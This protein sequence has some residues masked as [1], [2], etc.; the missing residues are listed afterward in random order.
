L[1]IVTPLRDAT[2]KLTGYSKILRDMTERKR[3]EDQLRLTEERFRRALSIGTVG[4][5]SFTLDGRLTDANGTF[6]RMSG[7][8]A[9]ELRALP[10][11]AVLTALPFTAVTDRVVDELAER[12]ETAPYEKQLLR[13]DGSSWWGLCAPTRL[14][15]SGRTAECLEFVIDITQAKAAAVA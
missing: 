4:V 3:A 14:A 2:G 11:W 1:G 13:K 5:L 9:D 8:T 6:E 7:Y 15:G 12:G 10:T